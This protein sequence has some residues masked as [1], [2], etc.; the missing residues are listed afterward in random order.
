MAPLFVRLTSPERI[1]FVCVGAKHVHPGPG[2]PDQ[3]L[4][5]L[6]SSSPS[7]GSGPLTGCLSEPG[8]QGG[9]STHGTVLSFARSVWTTLTGVGHR[10]GQ[11]LNR[12]FLGGQGSMI[13]T[14]G[15][16]AQYE[17]QSALSRRLHLGHKRPRCGSCRTDQPT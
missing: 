8:S 3:K 17:Y 5:S 11:L 10:L 9:G 16:G 2:Q 13:R 4:L 6:S 15:R 12:A 1:A 7:C 14:E